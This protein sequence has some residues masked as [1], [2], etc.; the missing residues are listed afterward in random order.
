M[1]VRADTA[2]SFLVEFPLGAPSGN[3][4]WKL[5]GPDGLVIVTQTVT[6][7]ADALS[8]NIQIDATENDLPSGSLT[9]YRD[10]EW[11]YSVNG[12]IINGEQRYVIEGRVPFGASVSGVR[13]KL[14][15]DDVLDLP[16]NEIS[17]VSAYT[18]FLQS[19]NATALAIADPADVRLRNTIEAIAALAILP[20]LMVRISKKEDSGTSSFQR[21]DIDW[22]AIAADLNNIIVTGYLFLD[23]GY[24]QTASFGA[25]FLLASP[26]TDAFT[27]DASA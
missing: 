21:Q 12:T 26:A 13:T 1:I 4:V 25:I 16:D 2:V 18:A 3:L 27:G 9:T 14:G 5:R 20:S 15:I 10:L 22:A 8:T 6:I 23:P 7:P 24:D 19:A 17:M 11:T